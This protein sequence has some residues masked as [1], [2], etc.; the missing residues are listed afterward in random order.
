MYDFEQPKVRSERRRR[1]ER[2]ISYLRSRSKSRAEGR[3]R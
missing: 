1:D 3:R 2:V